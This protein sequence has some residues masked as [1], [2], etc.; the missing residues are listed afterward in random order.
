MTTPPDEPTGANAAVQAHPN[1]AVVVHASGIHPS[2]SRLITLDAVTFNDAG[3]HG[4]SLHLAFNPGED[5]GPV[6]MHGLTHEEAGEATPFSKV[7]RQVDSLIDGRVLVVHDAPVAWGFLV[8]EARRAMNAAAKANRSRGRGRG[9]GRRRQK[10][11]HVPRPEAVVDTLA[12]ARR[13]TV[14]LAD[15]RIAA[16]ATQYGLDAPSPEASVERALLP[17]SVTSRELTEVLVELYLAQAARD[18]DAVASR[19]PK[20]MRADRFG[21]QRSHVRVDAVEAPRPLDNP[22][23]YQPGKEL[24]KGMEVVVAPEIE[25][26][27]NIII[28]ACMAEGLVYSE[29][30]TRQTSVVVCN[31]TTDLDGKAMHAQRK[32]IPLLA[33]TAF[34]AAIERMRG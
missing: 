11:G 25:M 28:E 9:R 27:P 21:L 20:D 4:E 30:L 2:T 15:T 5:P 31:E 16:V 10:V 1:V 8:S 29:K 6:H 24:A 26:D 34:M 12:T 13:Q 18:R 3:E 19:N 14:T 22:G 23:Q 17:E 32:G 33:D 7:L